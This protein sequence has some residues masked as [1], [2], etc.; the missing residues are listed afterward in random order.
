[1]AIQ[2][3]TRVSPS[4]AAG[5]A[6]VD[7]NPDKCPICNYAVTP[8]ESGV[9]IESGVSGPIWI[10]RVFQCP[11]VKCQRIFIARY[12]RR[13][14][15]EFELISCVPRELT[16]VSQSKIITEISPDFCEIYEQAFK[17]EQYQ[18]LLVAGPGY[19]KAL[20]FLIKD[21]IISQ[22]TEADP[23]R[24]AVHKKAVEKQLLGPCIIEYVKS[25]EIREISKR[26]VWLGNDETH[27]VRKWEGKDLADLKR[28]IQLT[29]HW[30]EMA[31]LT[32]DAIKDM[33]TG[34][35]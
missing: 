6:A 12:T 4:Q 20:E 7:T 28:L 8:L 10:E 3:N 15:A 32:A 31:R 24:M 33:P 18:L 35:T 34:K 22:Y 26:A 2:I 21:Y 5:R 16:K 14:S 25:E 11:N 13:L 29:L 1:M 30:I 27:Y 19:R 17:A 9:A 23:E